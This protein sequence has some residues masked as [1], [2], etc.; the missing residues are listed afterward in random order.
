MM[1]APPRPAI[2]VLSELPH[3]IET[4]RM[5][6]R[7]IANTDVEA[8]W[9]YASDPEVAKNM[10]WDPHEDRAET[11]AFITSAVD[12]LANNTR[13]VWAMEIDGAARG[14]I[15]L[16]GIRWTFRAWRIDRAELGYWLG[17]PYW[18]KGYMSEA[19]LAATAWGFET[20]GLH[21]ITIG[22][23]DGNTASQKIIEKLGFRFLAK[24]E[25]D[26]WRA[27]HWLH[28]LRY[29]M[30]AGEWSD[31]TSTGRFVRR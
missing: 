1:S 31:T 19:A 14:V 10:S 18:G 7:P 9:P 24:F 16:E 30:T 26:A 5:R 12:G 25:E 4:A 15:A 20:L 2:P 23:I 21:K 3:V 17:A 8:L 28:H 13:I 27:G 6:L 11:A 22:C 29:E